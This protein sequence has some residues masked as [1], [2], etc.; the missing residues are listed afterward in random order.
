MK[1]P[2]STNAINMVVHSHNYKS[3][4][5]T[6]HFVHLACF[7]SA[8]ASGCA[9]LLFINRSLGPKQGPFDA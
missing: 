2:S 4:F 8:D 1:L 5:N 9:L 6:L 7:F 3:A